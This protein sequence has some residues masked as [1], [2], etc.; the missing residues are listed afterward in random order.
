MRTGALLGVIAM[1]RL[2]QAMRP[3]WRFIAGVQDASSV[4]GMA[5]LMVALMKDENSAAPARSG[6]RRPCAR[7]AEGRLLLSG[8]GLFSGG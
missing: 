3:R 8:Y 1:I 6:S 5:L 2:A 4:L 7:P